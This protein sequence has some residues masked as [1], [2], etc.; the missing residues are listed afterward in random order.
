VTS[1]TR[2][3][4]CI[5]LLLLVLAS[6]VPLGSESRGTPHHILLRQLL[7]LPQ[8]GA[9]GPRIY[10]PQEQGGPDIPPATGFRFRCL[11]RLAGLRW[12]Y[13]I[14][15]PH[16]NKDWYDKFIVFIHTVVPMVCCTAQ[17]AM[18]VSGGQSLQHQSKMLTTIALFYTGTTSVE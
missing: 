2:G 8:P 9:P 16:G 7:R 18:A 11:L 12:R 10:I 17:E 13:S 1:L 14:P 4:V 15:P 5:L 6:A 3:R